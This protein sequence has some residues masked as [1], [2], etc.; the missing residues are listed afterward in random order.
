MVLIYGHCAGV[1][2]MPFVFTSSDVSN[3]FVMLEPVIR[4]SKCLVSSYAGGILNYSRSLDI[5][6]YI[7]TVYNFWI[8]STY[9]FGRKC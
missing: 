3:I 5:I 4:V 9:Y 1:L 7:C 8:P 6:Q 2:F